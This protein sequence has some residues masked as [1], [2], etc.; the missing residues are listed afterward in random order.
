M[1]LMYLVFLALSLA[2]SSLRLQRQ[3]GVQQGA[4]VI[5]RSD[6]AINPNSIIYPSMPTA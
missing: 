4:A 5:E 3:Q 6:T 1:I 2:S